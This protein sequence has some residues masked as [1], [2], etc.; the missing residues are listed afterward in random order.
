[1]AR[2]KLPLAAADQ[3]APPRSPV[4]L[5]LFAQG[6]EGVSRER[7]NG[8]S[9]AVQNITF[10]KPPGV[11]RQVLGQNEWGPRRLAKVQVINGP[12]ITVGLR[13]ESGPGTVITLFLDGNAPFGAA[14][15]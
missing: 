14:K 11:V 1:M 13:D 6:V 2:S 3:R 4:F 7:S 5:E 8:A 15:T 10:E 9:Q 12:R